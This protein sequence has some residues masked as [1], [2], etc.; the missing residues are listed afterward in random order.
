MVRW[1]FQK[2][3]NERSV[4]VRRAVSMLATESL[5]ADLDDRPNTVSAQTRQVLAQVPQASARAATMVREIGISVKGYSRYTAPATVRC[6]A[7]GIAQACVPD[8]D[9]LLL[10][11]LEG[12]VTDVEAI[13]SASVTDRQVRG[14]QTRSA[15]YLGRP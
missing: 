14:A 2:P 7:Y 3:K 4:T 6:S 9:G 1:P 12:A 8:P 15:S 13:V 5:L 10:D 11:V